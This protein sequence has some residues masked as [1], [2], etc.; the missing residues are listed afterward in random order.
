MPTTA[1][2]YPSP[3]GGTSV[4]QDLAPSHAK[5]TPVTFGDRT[6]PMF[7]TEFWTAKQRQASS[8]HE[9]SYRACF[10]PQLPRFFIEGLSE[11]GDVVY[12]PFMGRGTTIIEAVL[13]G[14]RSLGNDSNPLSR[15]LTIPRLDPPAFEDIIKRLERIKIASGRKSDTDLSMFYHPGTRDEIVSLRN[16]LSD[17][18]REGEEDRVDRWIRM[19][20]TNRLTGHSPGFFSVYTLPPNQ[21]ATQANQRKINKDRK[22]RPTYRDVKELILKKSRSLMRNVTPDQQSRI[23]EFAKQTA[24]FTGG[25]DKTKGINDSSVQ[26]TVTS[27]PFLDVV[28]Y[29]QDNWLRNWF[30]EI[31][32]AK[33]ACSMTVVRSPE[34]WCEEMQKVFQELY[35]VTRPGGFV[36]FEVG[37]VRKKNLKMEELVV[38]LG[39]KARFECLGILINRQSFT[40]TSNI[41]GIRNNVGG[42]NTN[43]IVLFQKLS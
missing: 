33:V 29:A 1:R 22:Q 9:I 38:P 27:P 16:Y 39:L 37:E 35:R 41:W 30:N 23:A 4:I 7:V 40:K 34:A 19:V 11:P 26:L 36:A 43:R 25:A 28:N 14:R 13:S 15:L 2:T 10:K 3:A 42:T 24:L 12:D 5:R 18:M 8:L 21:A 32:E 17:R 20:A 6:L 31:D